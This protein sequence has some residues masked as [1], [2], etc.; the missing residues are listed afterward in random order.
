MKTD[1]CEMKIKDGWASLKIDDAIGLNPDILKR[2]I[3]C[4]GKVRAHRAS[5]NGMRAHFEHVDAHSGCSLG[6][7]FTGKETLHPKALT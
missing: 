1:R 6:D 2:C 4:H 5:T 7:S 3:E